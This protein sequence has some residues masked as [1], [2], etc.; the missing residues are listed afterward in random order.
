MGKVWSYIGNTGII[1]SES[2]DES[3]ET[4]NKHSMSDNMNSLTVNHQ[5]CLISFLQID[6]VSAASLIVDARSTHLID[7][8]INKIFQSLT[9]GTGKGYYF[10]AFIEQNSD[11]VYSSI[12]KIAEEATK[13]SIVNFHRSF[14]QSV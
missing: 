2:N 14:P 3:P 12:C 11:F 4:T 5:N 6:P 7:E 10:D 8:F 1:P 9:K 13:N